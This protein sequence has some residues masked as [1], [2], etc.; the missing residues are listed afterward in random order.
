M[1]DNRRHVVWLAVCAA[2]LVQMLAGC[3]GGAGEESRGAEESIPVEVATAMRD[4]VSP[5]V[6]Y[7]GTVEAGRKALLG[8]EIQGQIE[9]MH[10]DVGD[11][12][13]AGDLMA[14][15][16]SEQLASARAHHVTASKD[17]ERARDLLEKKAITKQA[18]DH[19]LAALEVAR[20][21]HEMV[22]ASS[23]LRA[24]FDGFVTERY[25]DEGELYMLMPTT[26]AS[27]A[28]FD[29]ADISE[30]KIAFEVG[31]REREL[32]RKGLE[33]IVSVDSFPGRTF[34]GKVV[35]VDPSLDLMSRTATVE[36][37]V[38]N[39]GLE[40][41]PGVFA[42]VVLELTPR[43]ALVVPRDSMM[44]QEGTGLFFVY[45]VEDG[46]ARRRVIELG[47]GFGASIEVLDGL[48]GGEVI[49]TAG[50]H[51]LH[52][53]ARVAIRDAGGAGNEAQEA[54]SGA[55]GSGEEGTR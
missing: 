26:T 14:E 32:I 21:N 38:A 8:A 10:V 46:V 43:E 53:G 7:S 29:V 5:S 3:G 33:A 51:R 11:R 27:P 15:L 19:A 16:G 52:D 48:E 55:T 13:S 9:K 44:R 54:S 6:E 39:G 45:A 31:E 25:L 2:A 17:W 35:R 20:A 34:V 24:P 28:I 37:A 30:V 23:Q 12:V 36:V 50:R 4:M 40:L 18:Y 1:R 49:V 22:E 42:D 41:R 47:D